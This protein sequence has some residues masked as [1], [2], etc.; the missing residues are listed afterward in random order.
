MKKI[1]Y[2]SITLIPVVVLVLFTGCPSS[3][4]GGSGSYYIKATI[5]GSIYEWK[6]GLTDIEP[7]AFGS[8][9]PSDPGL[10]FVAS[11]TATSSA[12]PEPDNTIYIYI[13]PATAS[14]ATYTIGDFDWA[15]VRINGT[16]WDFT[17]ITLQVTAVNAVGGTIEGTL[18][19]TVQEYLG[20]ATMSVTNGE[21]MV[22]RA[23]NDAW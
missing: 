12:D 19:G 21:I 6:L 11:Q 8:Y 18:S 7:N 4:T 5:D 15:Y 13:T 20:S 9:Y 1:W 14:P 3:T 22:K 2:L 17:S 10:E 23:I 16:Y